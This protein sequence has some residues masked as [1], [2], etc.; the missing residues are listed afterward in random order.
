[1]AI[2]TPRSAAKRRRRFRTLSS[3][4]SVVRFMLS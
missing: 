3:K 4:L 1:V 2:E